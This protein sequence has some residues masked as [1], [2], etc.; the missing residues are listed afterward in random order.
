MISLLK[1]KLKNRSIVILGFGREG[2][3]TFCFLKKHLPQQKL[4]IA[5]KNNNAFADIITEANIKFYSGENYLEA[6]NSGDLIIKSPGIKLSQKWDNAEITSQTDLFLQYFHQQTIGITG[7]KGKSTTSS[8]IFHIIKQQTDNVILVGNIG[9]PA[10]DFIDKIDKKTKIVFELSAHQLQFIHKAP[11]IAIIL[12]LFEEHLDYFDNKGNYFNSKLNIHKFQDNNGHLIINTQPETNGAIKE[13]SFNCKNRWE[14]SFDKHPGNGA[15]SDEKNIFFNKQGELT[16]FSLTNIILKGKHNIL[17]IMAAITAAKIINIPDNRITEGI[18][19]FVGLPHRLEL[20]GIYNGITYYNDS[21]STIPE[22]TIEAL[23]TLK[24]TYTLILGGFDRNIDYKIL[25]TFLKS[26]SVKEIL[27]TGP[28]GK[29]MQKEYRSQQP[30]NQNSYFFD[31]FVQLISKAKTI[32]K[33]NTI[34]LLSPAASSYN[35]FKNFEERGKTF[36]TLIK[37]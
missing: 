2:R 19:T 25:Y 16:T 31:D 9:A 26:S 7:T 14:F 33:Q 21:I 3:S 1:E 29:R 10:F 22:T 27:F 32:T 11:H 36:N 35:A 4:I 13:S 23:K 37:I 12:N 20:A 8:L 15:W 18:N 28:A 30:K 5:D 17:N 34:C 6:C 24:E